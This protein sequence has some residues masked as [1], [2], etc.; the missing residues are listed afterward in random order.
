MDLK[1]ALINKEFH[2]RY[3]PQIDSETMEIIGA[4]ALI[5]LKK[6]DGVV[7]SPAFFIPELEKKGKIMEL[8]EEALKIVCSDIVD[9]QKNG[10]RFP[11]VSV[12]LSR[13]HMGRPDTADILNRIV[14]SYGVDKSQLVFELTESAV[15]RDDKEELNRLMGKLH[16]A[17]FKISLDDYGTGFS[18]LKLLADI[19]F[20][21]LKLDRYF[22]SKIGCPR[23]DKVLCSTIAMA[24][25]LGATVI[26]EG[27]ENI[28]QLSFLK[29]NGC[30][31][32][33]GYYFFRPLSKDDFLKKLSL[34]G[35]DLF[36]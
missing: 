21:F 31:L 35:K 27:V 30:F 12:N 33:Q 14:E 5:R 17:G 19:S 13:V 22:I 7:I 3:Q 6:Q 8:D 23:T 24:K 9:A 34:H 18:S 15:Y 4:E 20:D 16:S 11:A 32:A 25:A 29:E 2:V 10:I 26:A 36:P 28:K 1:K